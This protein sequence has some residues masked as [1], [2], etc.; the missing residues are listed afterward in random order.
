MWSLSD[1]LPERAQWGDVIDMIAAGLAFPIAV[2]AL[3]AIGITVSPDFDWVVD[4]LPYGAV[5]VALALKLFQ[6]ISESDIDSS[7][8]LHQVFWSCC[9]LPLALFWVLFF[10]GHAD[11]MSPVLLFSGWLVLMPLTF[12]PRFLVMVWMNSETPVGGK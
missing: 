9:V 11:A 12:I 10:Q 6:D 7:R 5:A 3:A 4:R 2:H 1:Y 8:R